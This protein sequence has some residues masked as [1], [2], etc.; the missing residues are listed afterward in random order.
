MARP[1]PLGV[2][3]HGIR[4]GTLTST[5]RP[6]HLDLRYST[7]ALDRW[8]GNTPLLSCSLPLSTRRLDARQYFRGLLPEGQHLN[9]LAARAG[10]SVTDL[11]GLLTRYGRDVAGA[12]T[13]LPD[14]ED[15]AGRN[16]GAVPY[17]DDTL[18]DDIAGLDEHPLAI[19]DDSELSLPGLQNKLLLI[20]SGA[21]WFR[22]TGGRPSTHILK[23]EDRR[24]PGLVTMEAAAMTLA[25][26]VGL[27]SVTVDIAT[28]GGIDCIIVERF[29]RVVAADG[30]VTRIHQEDVCQALGHD[31]DANQRRA[32]YEHG[33][34]PGL[35]KV[36][37]LL[38][39]HADDP[40]AELTRLTRAVTFTAV[41][42]NAD[43]H[44][45]N[46]SLLHS[47][48]GRIELAPLYDTVP[49]CLFPALKDRAAM[50][51]NGRTTLGR[52]TL[53][54]VVDEATR[55]PLAATTA[56]AA[57]HETVE[58][59]LDHLDGLPDRLVDA[60]T[61]RAGAFRSS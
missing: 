16:G 28:F 47:R 48:P 39:Q 3:L 9:N 50:F 29:D 27:T 58:A 5:G 44:A 42:G 59:I 35:A 32:K 7:E 57:A 60:V 61:Q 34:G 4:I 36:A 12:V 54:D 20:R 43:A 21:Q 1:E 56:R 37:A 17:D 14:G 46:I 30:S 38:E 53:D 25:R 15:P 22:P 10:I 45:K 26:R 13:V 40:V 19:H 6:Y 2:W 33:G 55:W 52:V 23:A 8:P 31:P 51:V 49:T 24:H 11:H 41:I 18:T